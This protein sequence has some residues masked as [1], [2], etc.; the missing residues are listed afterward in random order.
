MVPRGLALGDALIAACVERCPKRG[1][2]ALEWQTEKENLRAQAVY[3]RVGAV[4]EERLDYSI[5]VD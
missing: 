5:A 1:A 2:S 3:E 4:R